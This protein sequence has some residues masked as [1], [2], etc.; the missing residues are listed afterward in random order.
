MRRRGGGPAGPGDRLRGG[1]G[2]GNHVAR[3]LKLCREELSA[4]ARARRLGN[5]GAAR[6][7]QTALARVRLAR[8]ELAGGDAGLQQRKGAK[9]RGWRA[10]A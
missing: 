4:G 7:A 2:A 5:G 1:R 10:K 3:L 8:A 9:Q 6:L